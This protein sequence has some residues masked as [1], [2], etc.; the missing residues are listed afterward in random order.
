M[1]DYT[2]AIIYTDQLIE[3]VKTGDTTIDLVLSEEGMKNL[4]AKISERIYTTRDR[5]EL[6]KL[7]VEIE[8]NP[9]MSDWMKQDLL[10]AIEQQKWFE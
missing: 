8:N 10:W 1:S 3:K 9:R 5:R 7:E 2:N 6:S 4:E